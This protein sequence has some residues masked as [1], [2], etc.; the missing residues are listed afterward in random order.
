MAKLRRMNLPRPLFHSRYDDYHFGIGST[1][2]GTSGG[3]KCKMDKLLAIAHVLE[4]Y[5]EPVNKGRK[6]RKQSYQDGGDALFDIECPRVDG[7]LG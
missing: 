3:A 2:G 6:T 7:N 4:L 5:M 1:T